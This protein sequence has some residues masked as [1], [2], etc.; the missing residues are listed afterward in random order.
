MK[1]LV[2]GDSQSGATGAEVQ[3]L[4]Q[5]QGHQVIRKTNS[6][7]STKKLAAIAASLPRAW[8][9]VYLFSGG[10]D[11]AVQLDSLHQLLSHFAPSKRVVY[12]GPPPATLITNLGL[13]KKV[14]G[15]AKAPDKFFPQT[16]G[17]REKKNEAYLAHA[18]SKH[19]N[20][21]AKDFR[22]AKLS[23]AVVQPSGVV[24]PSQSDG[25][26]TRGQTSK[27][28]AQY[29]TVKQSA[30]LGDNAGVMFAVAAAVVGGAAAWWYFRGRGGA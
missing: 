23:N 7:K 20:V 5:A 3:K 12:A 22:K 27:E 9:E 26:H 30:L 29:L 17:F 15:S 25:I 6:G 24:Y 4:L 14:W 1:V 8:D 11:P 16:A 13:A 18:A 21:E 10:N 2:F 28:V 19:S